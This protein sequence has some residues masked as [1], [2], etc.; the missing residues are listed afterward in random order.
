MEQQFKC[1]GDCLKCHPA[2]RAYCTSQFTYNTMRLVE[3]LSADLGKM[4]GTVEELKQKI[5]A[6]QN[7][8]ANVF[9]P[10]NEELVIKDTN[11]AQEG[12]GAAQ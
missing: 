3:N 2:Q 12:D 4:V 10:T 11:I 1:S 9:N 7:S 8:E 5:E 6:I